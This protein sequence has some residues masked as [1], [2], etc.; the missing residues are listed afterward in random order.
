MKLNILLTLLAFII[1]QSLFAQKVGS[2]VSGGGARTYRKYAT[3]AVNTR[4][5]TASATVVKNRAVI[6]QFIQKYKAQGGAPQKIMIP[7][8]FIVEG[9]LG[10]AP[11]DQQ[12]A[13]QLDAL[14]QCFG[15]AAP[16]IK[17]EHPAYKKEKFEA[18]SAKP[19]IQFCLAKEFKVGTTTIKPIRRILPYGKEWTTDDKVKYTTEG[20]VDAIYPDQYLNIWV[21]QL[22][23]GV[24]GYAQQPGAATATDGIVISP[25]YF[26]TQPYFQYL[27]YNEGK[28][29]VHLVGSYLGVNELWNEKTPCGDDGVDDTPIHNSPNYGLFDKYKHLSTCLGN[30]VEMTMN[31]MDNTD[32]IAQYI[33]TEGQKMR[34]QAI[35]S[36]NG[37]RGKLANSGISQC[38]TT[39]L[40]DVTLRAASDPVAKKEAEAVVMYPNPAS[41]EITINVQTNAQSGY[42]MLVYNQLGSIVHQ[43][44]AS[45]EGNNQPITLDTAMW[46]EGVYYFQVRL[47]GRQYAQK[48]LIVH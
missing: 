1:A 7:V 10:L 21:A 12:I 46:Q 22:K 48:I 6:E 31:L 40:A 13:I 5:E 24:C 11:S 16:M 32:D 14:N 27:A 17:T 47:E 18:M 45:S 37:A 44:Q 35:V 4:L 3:Q 29:L 43:S 39:L 28:T 34:I 23:D 42:K 38:S 20:G 25:F 2:P 8:L 30:P 9:S 41:N 36:K 19:Q 33:F 26:G 15:E